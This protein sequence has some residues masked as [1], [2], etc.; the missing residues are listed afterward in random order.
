M[1]RLAKLEKIASERM[2]ELCESD[3]R[4][5]FHSE[6][7][8]YKYHPAKLHWRAAELD[9]TIAALNELAE[10]NADEIIKAVKWEGETFK[11]ETVYSGKTFQWS[12]K[13]VDEELHFTIKYDPIPGKHSLEMRLLM[14]MDK[15]GF[16]FPLVIMVTPG[17]EKFGFCDSAQGASITAQGNDEFLVKVPWGRFDYATEIFTGVLR[18]WSNEEGK[19]VYDNSP[20]TDYEIDPRLN[21]NGHAPERYA[22]LKL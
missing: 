15:S 19:M 16:K 12:V 3:C 17:G 9:K 11:P 4:L 18:L 6:A 2:A 22:L 7:E 10:K 13:K 5:G 8:I 14:L 21:F 20:V 1:I